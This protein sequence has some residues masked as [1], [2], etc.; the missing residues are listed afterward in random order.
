MKPGSDSNTSAASNGGLITSSEPHQIEENQSCPC[1]ANGNHCLAK[2]NNCLAKDNQ[3]L[4]KDNNCLAKDNQCLVKENQFLVKDN[5]CP[6]KDNQ[7]PV[8]DDHLLLDKDNENNLEVTIDTSTKPRKRKLSNKSIKKVTNKEKAPTKKKE[9][10]KDYV[11]IV[12]SDESFN[13]NDSSYIAIEEC[14]HSI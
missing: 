7:S 11:I 1:V 12:S 6:V 4:V 8:K 14:V 5:Q 2:D 3:C 10:K 9:K 13:T